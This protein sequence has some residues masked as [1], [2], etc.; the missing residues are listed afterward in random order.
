MPDLTPL[1][2]MRAFSTAPNLPSTRPNSQIA[3]DF[4]DLSFEMESGR[5]IERFTR[6]EGPITLHTVGRVSGVFQND[7]RA[8]LSRLQNEAGIT[9]TQVSAETDASINIELIPRTQLQSL[10]P[11]AACF[12]VPRVTSWN[13]YRRARNSSTTD[14]TTLTQRETVAIFIPNDVSP[15]EMR[16]CLHEEL[17]QALG[18]LNDLYRLPD[19]VFNDDNFHTVLTGFDMLMLRATYDSELSNGMTRSE[20]AARISNILARL[21][22]NGVVNTVDTRAD[23]P[24]AWK[25]EIEAALSPGTGALRRVNA[26]R[27]AIDIARAQNWNNTRLAFSLFAYA[28]IIAPTDSNAALAA[29]IEAREIYNTEPAT[30]TQSAHVLNHLALYALSAGDDTLAIQLS[31]AAIPIARRHQQAALLA[32]L[33]LIKSEA[34]QQMGQNASAR[35]IQLDSLAWARYGFGTEAEIN[36]RLGAISSLRLEPIPAGG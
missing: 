29:L 2:S 36:A 33:L 13:Q 24:R 6:F 35:A 9:I 27:R 14:W 8:L 21:N 19:S 11:Q 12:V 20:V 4:L 1:P 22:P 25:T 15:Q 23:T 7:L 32:T 34:L 10:V 28:R 3:Q 26:A 31:D 5:Q 16:D 17:A 18:P 30:D